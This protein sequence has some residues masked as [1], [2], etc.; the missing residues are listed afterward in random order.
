MHRRIVWSLSIASMAA[1]MLATTPARAQEEIVQSTGKGR[2]ILV[3]TGVTGLGTYRPIAT[4]ISALGYS[5]MLVDSVS[6]MKEGRAGAG[7]ALRAAI[8]KARQIPG[9]A[10]GKIAIVGFSLGGAIALGFGSMWNDDVAVVV[11]WYPMTTE[12]NDAKAFASRIRVPI[13]VFTGEA[14][15]YNSCCLVSKAREIENAAK[16]VNAP[17]ELTTYPGIKH[18]FVI[19]GRTYDAQAAEDAFNKMKVALKQY[20]GS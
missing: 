15:E 12:F 16:T 14:D 18:S 17:F 9:A 11:A 19:P 5:V 7:S 2:A 4:R 20:L 3:L 13:M 8:A 6:L 1:A 10:P